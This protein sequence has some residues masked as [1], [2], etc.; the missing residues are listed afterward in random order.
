MVLNEHWWERKPTN[1]VSLHLFS[2]LAVFILHF[3]SHTLRRNIITKLHKTKVTVLISICITKP[4][5]EESWEQLHDGSCLLHLSAAFI[6]FVCEC[7]LWENVLRVFVA[8]HTNNNGFRRTQPVSWTLSL[9]CSG[10]EGRLSR[11]LRGSRVPSRS[12]NWGLV[13]ASCHG[14]D[15]HLWG[16]F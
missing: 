9:L 13:K 6:I 1:S 15:S 14:G 7:P 2:L 3:C 5:V 4:F 12:A 11:C 16:Y 10:P 8:P